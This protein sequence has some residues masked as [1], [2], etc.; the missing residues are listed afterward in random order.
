MVYT[1]VPIRPGAPCF[2]LFPRIPT[3]PSIPVSPFIPFGPIGPCN[4]TISIIDSYNNTISYT[5]P[6]SRRSHCSFVTFRTL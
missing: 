2:P 4:Y 1:C 6:S 3:I 5:Y